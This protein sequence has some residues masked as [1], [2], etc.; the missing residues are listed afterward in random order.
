M[1]G[2]FTASPLVAALLIA[3]LAL[4]G[5]PAHAQTVMQAPATQSPATQPPATQPPVSGVP[6][7][8]ISS[9]R[10]NPGDELEIYVWGEER[11]QRD[12]TVLPDGTIAFPLVGQLQVADRLPQDVERMVSDRLKDQYRGEVP[13]VTVSV[14]APTGMRFSVL[15]KVRSPG[16]FTT[17]RYVNVL[18]A[19]S[20]AGG[21][22]EFANLDNVLLIRGTGPQSSSFQVRLGSLFKAGAGEQAVRRAGI[23]GV[24][25][26]DVIIVP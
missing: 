21:A 15:G 25:P 16:T 19:L 3:I 5:S 14:K 22:D 1:T 26:G 7:P 23:I 13:Y 4:A 2:R 10:I 12:L 6:T 18:E 24:Q 9:Y 11:L 20:Q 8:S 17:S